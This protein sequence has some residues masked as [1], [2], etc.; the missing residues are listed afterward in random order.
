LGGGGLKP[1]SSAVPG[2]FFYQVSREE[3]TWW[4]DH[5]QESNGRTL[6][7]KTVDFIIRDLCLSERLGIYCQGASIWGPWRLEEKR[8]HISCLEH[9]AIKTFI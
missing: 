9:R 7:Q 8:L 6:F 2:I 4:R 3:I 1:P 5:L